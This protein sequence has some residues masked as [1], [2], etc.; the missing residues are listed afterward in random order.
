MS[1]LDPDSYRAHLDAHPVDEDDAIGHIRRDLAYQGPGDPTDG[2]REFYQRVLAQYDELAAAVDQLSET[3]LAGVRARG[4]GE[5]VTLDPSTMKTGSW[6][7]KTGF[8]FSQQNP[9]RAEGEED[10]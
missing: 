2:N 6:S 3:L 9:P 4:L 10:R 8:R 5:A 7:P 1:T